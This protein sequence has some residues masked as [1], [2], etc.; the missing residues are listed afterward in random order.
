MLKLFL[1]FGGDIHIPGPPG[2]PTPT[3]LIHQIILRK[4]L[5]KGERMRLVQFLVIEQG[6]DVNALSSRGE[7]PFYLCA[8]EGRL[9]FCK[10]IAERGA[11][12]FARDKELGNALHTAAKNDHLN[13]CR[14]LV[15]DLGFDVDAKDDSKKTPLCYAA[16]QGHI[17]LCKYLL[18]RGA[19]VDAGFQPLYVAAQVSTLFCF[20]IL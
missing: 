1:R 3:Y 19:I 20:L 13:I 8:Q 5:E 11:N 4:A 16:C 7:S 12:P 6:V 18:E 2:S 9:D 14:Y 17:E 15:E 10:L